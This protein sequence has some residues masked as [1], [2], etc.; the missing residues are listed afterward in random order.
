MSSSFLLRASESLVSI[1]R[2]SGETW[3]S[4]SPASTMRRA[5]RSLPSSSASSASGARFASET[6]SFVLW[7]YCSSRL[8]YSR[9]SRT[10]SSF[11]SLAFSSFS[12]C[13]LRKRRCGAISLRRLSTCLIF[14]S[15]FRSLS[16]S[17]SFLKYSLILSQVTFKNEAW[18]FSGSDHLV[19]RVNFSFL[20]W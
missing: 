18:V 7:T 12:T 2:I 10:S 9:A 13:F 14:S 19:T 15:V 6:A 17:S 1:V 8:K 11:I 5:S 20:Y 3:V 4:V 16:F